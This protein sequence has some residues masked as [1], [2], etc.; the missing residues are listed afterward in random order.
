MKLAIWVGGAVVAL[1]LILII[2]PFYTIR[3]GY[4]GLVLNWGALQSQVIEPG[5]HFRIP[6]MQHIEK[7]SVQPIEVDYNIPVGTD[8]AITKDNQTIGADTVIYFVYEES[9]L[10]EMRQ[11]YGEAKLRTL[12]QS[13]VKE[14][15]KDIIGE[16]SVFDIAPSQEKIRGMVKENLL[17]KVSAYPLKL[18]DLR[19]QNYDWADSFDQQI[20]ETNNKAQQVKQAEQELLITQQNAQKQVKEAES[21]KQALITKAEGEKEAAK[22]MAEAKALEGEGIR[23]Y[24]VSVQNNMELEV[25]LR[26]LEIEKIRA[27]HW[28]GQNVPSQVFSPI[29]LNLDPSFVK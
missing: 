19:I 6:I 18:T 14:S 10:V 16:F 7:F 3:A 2:N 9:R 1:V 4:K 20:Q 21:A 17:K 8:G 29:P 22:L 25:K 12:V 13:A 28:N 24:N 27:E 15:F 26:Q 11:N 5:L 23:K